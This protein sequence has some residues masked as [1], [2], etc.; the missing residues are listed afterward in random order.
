MLALIVVAIVVV[1]VLIVRQMRA[2]GLIPFRKERC[3]HC[4]AHAP[5]EEVT[6]YKNTGM[7]VM[8]HVERVRGTLCRRCAS[9]LFVRTM[10]HTLTLGWWGFIS[11]F[12]NLLF[13]ANNLYVF[14]WTQTLPDGA[15]AA[16]TDLEG[17]RE[18]ARNLLAT[19]DRETV[20]EVLVRAT[21]ASPEEVARF[22]DRMG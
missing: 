3:E 4:G 16:K 10:L 8:F 12:A 11:F 1:G 15:T 9:E 18:Y 19:K 20:V 17:Q 22:L 5:V 14:V 6:L 21:R 7:I 13:V 2:S